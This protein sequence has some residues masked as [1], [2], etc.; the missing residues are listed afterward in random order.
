MMENLRLK[1]VA[2]KTESVGG[3]RW[4]KFRGPVGRRVQGK[5][6]RTIQSTGSTGVY[7]RPGEEPCKA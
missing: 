2:I 7:P 6:P 4:R 5:V 1:M 3:G